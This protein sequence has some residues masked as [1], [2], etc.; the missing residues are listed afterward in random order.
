MGGVDRLA[1][2]AITFALAAREGLYDDAVT[3]RHGEH[4]AVDHAIAHV[5]LRNQP[6]DLAAYRNERLVLPQRPRAVAGAV[7]DH[8]LAQAGDLRGRLELGTPELA[9][10]DEEDRKSTRLNSSHT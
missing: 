5:G 10:G 7:D 3:P 6:R 8:L 1:G 4:A 2:I 9:T